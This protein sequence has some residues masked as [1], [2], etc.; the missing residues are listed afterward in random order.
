MSSAEQ[1][2]VC[3]YLS[4]T[5][6][7]LHV[8]KTQLLPNFAG[9]LLYILLCRAEQSR[10]QVEQ[11]VE[12]SRVEQSRVHTYVAKAIARRQLHNYRFTFL[13]GEEI[14]MHIF[15]LRY[16]QPLRVL[17]LG[18]V[19]RCLSIILFV[20][21]GI[22]ALLYHREKSRQVYILYSRWDVEQSR[23]F[24]RYVLCMHPSSHL[25]ISTEAEAEA[26]LVS[27]NCCIFG[28]RSSIPTVK[29]LT[30][31]TPLPS[32]ARV[33]RGT[34]KLINNENLPLSLSPSLYLISAF[35]QLIVQSS[36]Q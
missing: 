26:E 1:S 19:V 8:L 15:I 2:R 20:P 29:G 34:V 22:A 18:N 35:G 36:I 16:I 24:A 25:H 11:S 23:V 5:R 9:Y 6:D 10:T 28:P 27:P 30:E 12:K 14:C 21:S 32:P 17:Y 3:T 33:G 4:W 31:V 7:V 13:L